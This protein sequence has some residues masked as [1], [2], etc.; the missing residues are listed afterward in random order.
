MAESDRV[1]RSAPAVV[2]DTTRGCFEGRERWQ[3]TNREV[4]ERLKHHV[5]SENLHARA[6]ALPRRLD[7]VVVR[8]GLPLD[9]AKKAEVYTARGYLEEM[10]ER[11]RM[12][13]EHP[14]DSEPSHVS[15]A[16]E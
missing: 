16:C 6:E 5:R 12:G 13:D 4:R 10:K 9:E 7:I 1:L 8:S 11:V 3:V 15:R 2:I 14:R